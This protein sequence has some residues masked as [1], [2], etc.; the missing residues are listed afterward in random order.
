MFKAPCKK[1][2]L[3]CITSPKGDDDEELSEEGEKARWRCK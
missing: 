1:R 3:F 2:S